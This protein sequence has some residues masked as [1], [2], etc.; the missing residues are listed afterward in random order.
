M[1]FLQA[2]SHDV[3]DSRSR[4]LADTGVRRIIYSTLGDDDALKDLRIAAGTLQPEEKRILIAELR[5]RSG[6]GKVAARMAA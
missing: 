4:R 2:K 5:L 1:A 3:S 6:R